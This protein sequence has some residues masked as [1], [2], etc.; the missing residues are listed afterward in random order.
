MRLKLPTIVTVSVILAACTSYSGVKSIGK[1]TY[2]EARTKSV[3]ASG[4]EALADLYG[5]ANEFCAEKGLNFVSVHENYSDG[6]PGHLASA[7]LQFRCVP[8]DDRENKRPIIKR[9]P[10]I[11]V[12]TK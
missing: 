11:I 6:K 2:M 8:E 7:I 5:D 12:E 10:D 1:D 9:D 4:G 3:L